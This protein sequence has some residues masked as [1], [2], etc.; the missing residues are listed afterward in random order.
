[1]MSID[2]LFGI[3][4]TFSLLCSIVLHAV[5]VTLF[6]MMNAKHRLCTKVVF[7]ISTPSIIGWILVRVANL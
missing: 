6:Q 1:M 4:G 2:T 7:T 5:A 3:K